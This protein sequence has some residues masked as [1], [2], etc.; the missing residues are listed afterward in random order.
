MKVRIQL[1]SA[2]AKGAMRRWGGEFRSSVQKAVT[3]ALKAEAKPIEKTIRDH[4]GSHLHIQRGGFLNSF[5]VR[6]W[7]KNTTRL[8][9]LHIGS[10][11]PW[12]GIHEHGGV[13][14]GPVLIPLFGRIG[15]KR[16]KAIVEQ[17]LRGGNAFFIRKNGR[18]LLM[19]ENLRE[20][21]RPLA[22]FKRGYRQSEGIAR[23][24]RGDA[25]PI[26]VLLPRV[27][28]KKRLDVAALALRQIPRLAQ[29]IDAQLKTLD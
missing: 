13:I 20:H 23:L 27:A 14:G 10:K 22:R 21:D 18:T 17:L 26:A 16:F 19:A 12:V 28:L 7:A 15:R 5:R 3:Q 24:K 11:V 29:A 2:A 6:V 9:A 25:I 8:P 1:D 4:V